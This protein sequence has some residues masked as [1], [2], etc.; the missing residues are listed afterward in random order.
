MVGSQFRSR[1]SGHLVL[2]CFPSEP[3][4]S[5]IGAAAD[6]GPLS[7]VARD[8]KA[9]SEVGKAGGTVAPESNDRRSK[10]GRADDSLRACNSSGPGPADGAGDGFS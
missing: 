1:G 9:R 3:R 5:V 7:R 8:R 4:N 10:G 2:L 6:R